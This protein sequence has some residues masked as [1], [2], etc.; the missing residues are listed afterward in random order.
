[1]S[2]GYQNGALLPPYHKMFLAPEA[3]GVLTYTPKA[4]NISGQPHKSDVI[5]KS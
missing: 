5:H 2:W 1:M 3:R 4:G